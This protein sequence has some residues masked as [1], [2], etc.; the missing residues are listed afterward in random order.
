VQEGGQRDRGEHLA[1]LADGTHALGEEGKG[2]PAE[3]GRDELGD[4]NESHRIAR[5]DED[6]PDDRDH[7]VRRERH[8]YLSDRHQRRAD[9]DEPAGSDPVKD[10]ADRDLQRRVDDE[11]HDGEGGE[12][13]RLHLETLGRVDARHPE[14]GALQDGDDVGEDSDREDDPGSAGVHPPNLLGPM[15]AG[16]RRR[17]RA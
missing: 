8:G 17:P 12:Q 9:Q 11:L 1:E 6:A 4:G 16:S 7:D 13:G 15:A 10:D 3:P 2:A 14:G 5:A